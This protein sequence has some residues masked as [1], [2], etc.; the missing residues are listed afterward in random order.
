MRS[1]WVL[2]AQSLD[3]IA[4]P[5]QTVTEITGDRVDIGLAASCDQRLL[6]RSSS[7]AR[8]GTSAAPIGDFEM[9]R[10][11]I[12]AAL[13]VAGLLTGSRIALADVEE[14]SPK[15]T[16]IIAYDGWELS[17]APIWNWVVDADKVAD[18]NLAAPNT[19]SFP[20][21]NGPLSEYDVNIPQATRSH[22]I[23][24]LPAVDPLYFHS[25]FDKGNSSNIRAFMS[26]SAHPL[27]TLTPRRHPTSMSPPGGCARCVG[28]VAPATADRAKLFAALFSSTFFPKGGSVVQRHQVTGTV[29]ERDAPLLVSL[30]RSM[31]LAP[32]SV[33]RL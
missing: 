32:P 5:R 12:G 7:A 26:E 21:E 33:L 6:R 18:D 9:S 22:T 24:N 8:A 30:H 19:I 1:N 31:R 11:H 28:E 14:G 17:G 23:D 10:K 2:S 16:E 3:Q 29:R 4:S 27:R 20:S 15:R 13:A 25:N